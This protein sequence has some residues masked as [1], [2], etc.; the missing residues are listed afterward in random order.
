MLDKAFLPWKRYKTIKSKCYHVHEEATSRFE[1][2]GALLSF[3]RIV[4]RIRNIIAAEII[5]DHVVVFFPADP[6]ERKAVGDIFNR[7]K[8]EEVLLRNELRFNFEPLAD[9]G[10]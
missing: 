2:D 4:G 9:V 7:Q 8:T 5:L 1:R 6:T 10:P 3:N